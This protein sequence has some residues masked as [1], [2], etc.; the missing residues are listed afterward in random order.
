MEFSKSIRTEQTPYL[1]VSF[2]VLK[3]NVN[4]PPSRLKDCGDTEVVVH[5]IS[6]F[7]LHFSILKVF[8]RTSLSALIICSALTHTHALSVDYSK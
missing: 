3:R 1:S 4:L 2:V 8:S 5:T 6:L 7:A